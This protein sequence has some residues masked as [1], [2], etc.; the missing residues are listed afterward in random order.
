[1]GDPAAIMVNDSLRAR[2]AESSAAGVYVT[3]TE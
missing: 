2:R 3:R 1:M